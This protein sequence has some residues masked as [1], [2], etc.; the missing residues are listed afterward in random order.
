VIERVDFKGGGGGS[1]VAV[2]RGREVKRGMIGKKGVRGEI[3][4]EGGKG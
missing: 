1:E 4:G 2:G 3:K